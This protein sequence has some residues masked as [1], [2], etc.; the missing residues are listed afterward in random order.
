M[1]HVREA[2]AE[3]D[4]SYAEEAP[5]CE[6]SKFAARAT[7]ARVGRWPPDSVSPGR[8]FAADETVCRGDEKAASHCLTCG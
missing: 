6:N 4:K 7:S 2:D 5:N 1:Q 8:A 3:V